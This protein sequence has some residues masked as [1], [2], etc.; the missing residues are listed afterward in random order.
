M[1]G[2][3]GYMQMMNE[4]IDFVSEVLDSVTEGKLVTG[5]LG[6]GIL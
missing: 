2:W 6:N 4:L 1:T 5:E 3:V